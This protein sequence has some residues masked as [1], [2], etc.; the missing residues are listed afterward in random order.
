[1]IV[2]RLK[3]S[4]VTKIWLKGSKVTKIWLKGFVDIFYL[5]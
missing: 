2:Q 3:G 1:M 5:Y 4:K